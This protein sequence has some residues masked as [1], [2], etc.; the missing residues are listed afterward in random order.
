MEPE[1]GG[2]GAIIT[3][4]DKI[5]ERRLGFYKDDIDNINGI[6]KKFLG[7]SDSKCIMLID[8]EGYMVSKCGT[9]EDFN[10][11]ALA[12]LVA[13][14]F[15]AT[16][17][18]A[19]ILGENELSVLFHQ[20]KRDSI[21]LNLTGERTILVAVFD[22]RTTMGMVRLYAKEASEQLLR[23]FED[24]VDREENKSASSQER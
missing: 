8:K 20:G 21:Q 5:R 11:Q 22:E 24:I 18:M 2:S 3:D 4:S 9:T 1:A 7:L 17:E 10:I 14:S 6:L 16:R 19:R 23:T 12:T 13:G 15:A